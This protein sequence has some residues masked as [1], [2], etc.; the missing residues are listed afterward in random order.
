MCSEDLFLAA[1]RRPANILPSK[2]KYPCLLPTM[3]RHNTK[4]IFQFA[5]SIPH[6]GVAVGSES[7]LS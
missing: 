7:R 2:K 1:Q 3:T 6:I 4:Q 5:S